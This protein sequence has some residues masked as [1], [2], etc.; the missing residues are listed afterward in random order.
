MKQ[1]ESKIKY[2]DDRIAALRKELNEAIIDTLKNNNLTEIK[3]SQHFDHQTYVISFDRHNSGN[4]VRVTHVSLIDN[5]FEITA[6]DEQNDS[7]E[8]LSAQY[9]DIAC[10]NIDWLVSML[11]D[12]NY[13]LSLPNSEGEIEIADKRIHWRFDEPGLTSLTQEEMEC[14]TTALDNGSTDGTL[15]R[16]SDEYPPLEGEWYVVERST[17]I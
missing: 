7:S 11:D 8:T 16:E 10:K 17:R 5:G 13:T 15:Y 1:M 12:M 4:D 14:I 2:F 6:Y 9:G 3:L